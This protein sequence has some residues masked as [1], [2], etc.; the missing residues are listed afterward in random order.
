MSQSLESTGP[1]AATL[2]LVDDEPAVLRL[3]VEV[4]GEGGYATLEAADGL[5]ALEAAR[6]HPGRIDLVVTDV[7]MPRMGGLE[8]RDALSTER[9]E[10]RFLF[11]SGS[12]LE[13]LAT[14][15]RALSSANFLGKPFTPEQLLAKV[16]A[17][18]GR[19]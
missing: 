4:L 11:V 17:V 13:A 7:S 6:G 8:L 16:A 1:G 18:L 5:G 14:Q 9:P 12:A 15:D 2:L 19:A 3:L 10:A